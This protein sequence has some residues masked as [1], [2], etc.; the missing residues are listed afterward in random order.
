M[1]LIIY[2]FASA[3]SL[4]SLGAPPGLLTSIYPH[5][6]ITFCPSFYTFFSCS[7]LL[8]FFTFLLSINVVLLCFLLLWV[9][10]A[11][12]QEQVGLSVFRLWPLNPLLVLSTRSAA[13]LTPV[14]M[15]GDGLVTR[16]TALRQLC[17]CG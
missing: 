16:E 6:Q 5:L 2:C 17:L 14:E 8:F 9:L 4:F 1:S 3:K 10:C 7:F 12:P 15:H 11:A 13:H